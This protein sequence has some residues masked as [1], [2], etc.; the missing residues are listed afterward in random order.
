MQEFDGKAKCKMTFAYS[1]PNLLD[2]LCTI[3]HGRIVEGECGGRRPPLFF[4]G[5]AFAD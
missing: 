5:D 4:K 1:K 2:H 3:R